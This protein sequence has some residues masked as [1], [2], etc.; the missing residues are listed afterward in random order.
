MPKLTD[1]AVR[2]LKPADKAYKRPDGQ[3][4]Y[5]LVTATG[6]YFRYD[7]RHAGKRKTLALGVYPCHLAEVA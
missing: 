1:T 3:G 5:L 4:L 7:Y 6:R 2:N